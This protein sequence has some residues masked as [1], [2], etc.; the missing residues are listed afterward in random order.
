MKQHTAVV[1]DSWRND[2][3]ETDGKK[4]HPLNCSVRGGNVAEDGCCCLL[5]WGRAAGGFQ[6]QHHL[7]SCHHLLP[8]R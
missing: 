3:A 5:W 6:R 2:T 7:I 4:T 8:G 1:E